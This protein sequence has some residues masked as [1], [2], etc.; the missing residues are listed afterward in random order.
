M[1]FLE[2]LFSAGKAFLREAAKFVVETV[3]VVLHEVDQSSFGRAATDFLRG[4]TQRYF[5]QAR[6]LAAEEIELAQK[7]RMD[8]RL[9]E[10]DLDRLRTI[11][12][13]RGKLRLALDDAKAVEAAEVLRE[14]QDEVI[15][16]PLTGDELSSAVGILSTKVCPECGGSMRIRQTPFNEA[17]QGYGF[18]WQCTAQNALPCPTVKLDPRADQ[19]AVVRRPDADLD[20]PGTKRR[21][22][23]NNPALMAQTHTRLRSGLGDDDESVVCP[24]HLLPMKLMPVARPGGLM[25]DSY[26]YACLGVDPMGRACAH[27]VPVL[28]FPQVSAALR[29]RDGRGILDS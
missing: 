20:G 24:H 8:G 19:S 27:T 26:Q 15:Q 29:R 6:D 10:R 23:W 21:A 5:G 3:R 11:E 16:V 12:A 25:L 13:E 18:Y 1:S 9:S 4:A 17:R 22:E 7:R 14:V 28:T 2:S